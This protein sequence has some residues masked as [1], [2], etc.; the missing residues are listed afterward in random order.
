MYMYK[1]CNYTNPLHRIN[2][3]GKNNKTLWYTRCIITVLYHA[4]QHMYFVKKYSPFIYINFNFLLAKEKTLNYGFCGSQIGPQLRK[5]RTW[6]CVRLLG[7][8]RP[9][10][11]YQHCSSMPNLSTVR[12]PSVAKMRSRWTGELWGSSRGQWWWWCFFSIFFVLYLILCL[13][14]KRVHFIYLHTLH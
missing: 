8:S 12:G 10:K 6:F 4:V 5:C 11:W 14:L 3:T 13:W 1:N 9:I 7:S 2:C